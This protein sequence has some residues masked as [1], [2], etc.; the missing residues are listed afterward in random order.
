MLLGDGDARPES[1]PSCARLELPRARRRAAAAAGRAARHARGRP[2][3]GPLTRGAARRSSQV[4]RQGGKAIVLVNRRGSSPS[5]LQLLRRGPGLPPLRRLATSSTAA[6]ARLPPLRPRR[7]GAAGCPACG[8]VSIVRPAP[9]PSGS[10]RSCGELVGRCRSSASTPTPPRQ[11]RH[12][13]LLARFRRGASG[14]LVG[15][16]MVAKGHDFPEVTLSVIV[17]ADSTLRF[18]DFRAE[19]RT[20]ALV[21]QLAG[22]SGRGERRPGPGPDARPGAP[23]S[24][25]GATTRRVSSPG[26]R[27]AP[28]VRLPAV[29]ASDRIGLPGRRA[30]PRHRPRTPWR[31][32]SRRLGP[33][34]AARPGAALPLAGPLPAPAARQ[35]RRAAAAV[36][37]VRD[38]V[39]A[40]VDDRRAAR[41]HARGGCRSAV[42]PT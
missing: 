27:A 21:A 34:R 19:E 8:S 31:A 14:A 25:P 40:A 4:A 33:S 5:E 2:R 18:P 24:P 28:R 20:F 41:G 7:A 37:A 32:R 6:A 16:Q 35:V 3:R 22:R 23:G 10:R 38:A 39:G 17:D 36:A 11:A 26:D 29:L 30:P 9:G 12:A 42:G 15:T 1:W 13:E